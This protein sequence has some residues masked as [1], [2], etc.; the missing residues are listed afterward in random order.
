VLE[1]RA[2]EEIPTADWLTVADQRHY[3]ETMITIFRAVDVAVAQ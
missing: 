3:G 2:D 1:H